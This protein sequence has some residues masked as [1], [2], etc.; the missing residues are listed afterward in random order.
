MTQIHASNAKMSKKM[1]SFLQEFFFLLINDSYISLSEVFIA[2][3]K[4]KIIVTAEGLKV[5]I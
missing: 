2:L 4:I 3:F 5:L 1:L